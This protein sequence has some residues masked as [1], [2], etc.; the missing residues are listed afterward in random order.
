MHLFQS[1]TIPFQFRHIRSSSSSFT[2]SI[3]F[4]Q[5]LT[6]GI[7][8][9]GFQSNT[10]LIYASVLHCIACS[11]YCIL[12][13]FIDLLIVTILNSSCSSWLNFL[14]YW[15]VLVFLTGSHIFF[16]IVFSKI[17]II[18]QWHLLWFVF[19]NHMQVSAL[20]IIAVYNSTFV[21]FEKSFDLKKLKKYKK[22]VFCFCYA[23][24]SQ[25]FF[26]LSNTLRY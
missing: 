7:F 4:F 23:S 14:H 17:F 16:R 10:N 3:H 1:R 2:T 13:F 5:G 6:Y 12:W 20:F 19:Y 22:R 15:P 11:N 8:Y 9:S 26:A 24:I 25:N 21:R 18:S